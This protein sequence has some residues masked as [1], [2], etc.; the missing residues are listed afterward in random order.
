[1]KTFKEFILNEAKVIRRNLPINT[2][3]TLI[4]SF[5]SGGLLDNPMT[6]ENCGRPIA[7]IGVV[8]N[9]EGQTFD[10]GMDCAST[11]SGI[12]DTLGFDQNMNN[13][14]EATAVRNKIR[15][16]Q[17][18]YPN[19]IV[20]A[21]ILP[22]GDVSIIMEDER[23]RPLFRI[24]HPLEFV[25]KYLPD[26]QKYIVN[27]NKIDF[28]P[29]FLKDHDFNFDFSK[30]TQPRLRQN[31]YSFNV[32]SYN[33]V[34]KDIQEKAMSGNINDIIN[35]TI[36]QNGKELYNTQTYMARD[37][38]DKIIWGLNKIELGE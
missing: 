13:F 29:K 14:N 9:A 10:V 3:Y 27:K 8:K 30:I 20:S 7:N 12:K 24:Y 11:L 17:K 15:T 22:S 34:I 32:D 2:T 16:Q 28:K 4:D 38:K 5:Y 37:V 36:S 23:E 19:G 21:E 25:K 1:M 35:I 26:L 18:K 31:D 6:C 33:V